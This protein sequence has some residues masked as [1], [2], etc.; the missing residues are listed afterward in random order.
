MGDNV[1]R[2]FDDVRGGIVPS[3]LLPE[4]LTANGSIHSRI[5]NDSSG[6]RSGRNPSG[7]GRKPALPERVLNPATDP[8]CK[9]PPGKRFGDYFTPS[10]ADLKANCASW[11]VFPHHLPPHKEMPMC[12][13]L[14][15]TGGCN[16]DCRHAHVSPSEMNPNTW[17]DIRARLVKILGT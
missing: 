7:G 2:F 14:Q 11:P 6:G 8:A 10:R 12:L 13:R 3:V 17:K 5:T 1:A 16:K 4:S 9:I 15:T